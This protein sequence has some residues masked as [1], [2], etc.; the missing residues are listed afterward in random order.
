MGRSVS[1]AE[2]VEDVDC[3]PI[4]IVDGLTKNWRLPGW[5]TCWAVGP[6][7][8]I[9]AMQSAGSFLDGGATHILH[10]EFAK[11]DATVLQRHFKAKRD[12]VLERLK[13]LGFKIDAEPQG[14]FYI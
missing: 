14:T 2:F 4:I 8:V 10:P 5:R 1:S 12:F 13:S 11:K 3:D 7:D 9:E 6:A